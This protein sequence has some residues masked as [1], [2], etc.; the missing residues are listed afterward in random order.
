MPRRH[1]I[2]IAMDARTK[3]A[4]MSFLSAGPLPDGLKCLLRIVADGEHRDATTAH[5]YK[6]YSPETVRAVSAAFLSEVLFAHQSDPYRVLGLSP[7]APLAEVREHKRL[8]LKWLHPDRNPELREH[9]KLACV[10]RAAEAIERDHRHQFIRPESARHLWPAA[11]A[12]VE[13]AGA[14]G[15]A[16]VRSEPTS[17]ETAREA[18]QIASRV[19][20]RFRRVAKLSLTYFTLMVSILIAWRFVMAEPFGASLTRYLKLTLGVFAW[21]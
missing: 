5:V 1:A 11:K 18:I 9:E 14:E 17:Q 7:G 4:V 10:I 12:G 3:P 15:L 8:L 19:V 6:T 13:G 2:Y 16:D 21:P 20:F